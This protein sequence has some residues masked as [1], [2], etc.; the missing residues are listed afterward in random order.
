MH[1]LKKLVHDIKK[2]LTLADYIILGVVIFTGIL[3]F[4]FFRRVNTTITIRMKITDSDVQYMNVRP[5]DE[6]AANFIVGD[7]EMNELGQTT[8]E[9]TRVDTYHTE[10]DKQVVYLTM[11]VNA[12]YNPRNQQY[13]V[14]GIPIVVGQS[15]IFT[16]THIRLQGIVVAFPLTSTIIGRPKTF[17]VKAQLRDTSDSRQYSDTYGVPDFVSQS[18]KPGDVITNSEGTILIKVLV[19]NIQPAKR[20]IVTQENTSLTIYD[21]ELKDVF[22]TLEIHGFTN[23]NMLFTYDYLPIFVGQILP[24]TFPHTSIKPTVTEIE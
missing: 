13:S 4:V 18:V 11:R 7:K 8:A 10:P 12:N 6:Y 24:L 14:K 2:Q 21:Q 16:L 20:T 15:L 3:L 19:V 9:I 1:K 5:L 23:N 17:V 22:Y